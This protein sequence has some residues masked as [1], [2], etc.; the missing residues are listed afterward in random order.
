MGRVDSARTGEPTAFRQKTK[1]YI[2]KKKK[3]SPMLDQIKPDGL[4][5]D[6]V[7]GLGEVLENHDQLLVAEDELL[8]GGICAANIDGREVSIIEIS[9]GL[10]F[11][12]QLYACVPEAMQV[13]A[14][15]RFF[16]PDLIACHTG[17]G[18]K[19][20]WTRNSRQGEARTPDHADYQL[21]AAS[22]VVEDGAIRI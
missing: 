18:S 6:Y 14:H 2:F 7:R 15:H 1:L 19:E 17:A 9:I 4:G 5:H 16:S 8:T 21:G 11:I 10:A 13:S 22:N 12:S 3:Q 20:G